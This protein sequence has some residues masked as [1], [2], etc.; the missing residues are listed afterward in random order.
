MADVGTVDRAR[1]SYVLG[2]TLGDLDP[3]H[4]EALDELFAGLVEALQRTDSDDDGLVDAA[5]AT[6]GPGSADVVARRRERARALAPDART[7]NRIDRT[8]G[9]LVIAEE[10]ADLLAHL[11]L[12][13]GGPPPVGRFRVAVHPDAD[14]DTGADDGW[15]V[16]VAARDEPGLLARIALALHHRG[17]SVRSAAVAAYSDRVALDIF[18]VTGPEPSA[19]ELEDAV[20]DAFRT[21][22]VPTAVPGAEVRVDQGASRWSS[23]CTVTT[24]DRP[25]LLW[26]LTATMA[27]LDLVV[28]SARI[29]TDGDRASDRFDL[30]DRKGRKLDATTVQRLRSAIMGD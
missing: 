6:V 17:L 12:V 21:P 18:R 13:A 3:T 22:L 7:R 30:T 19:D 10:P 20:L 5:S 2:L 1:R 9:A 15:R 27:A 8:P 28:H 25:G 29:G 16:A 14:Q 11:A 4:R 26:E 24:P 23:V